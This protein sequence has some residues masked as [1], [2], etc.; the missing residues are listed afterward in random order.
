MSYKEQFL[1]ASDL[2]NEKDAQI[3]RLEDK[4]TEARYQ[5]ERA[6]AQLESL[7]ESQQLVAESVLAQLQAYLNS[8]KE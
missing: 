8:V 4:L 1:L 6:V 3:E 5:I 2:L 7:K